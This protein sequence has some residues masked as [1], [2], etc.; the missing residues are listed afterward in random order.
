LHYLTVFFQRLRG[1]L[2][3]EH[4]LEGIEGLAIA[5]PYE[6]SVAVHARVIGCIGIGIR[7]IISVLHLTSIIINKIGCGCQIISA[8]KCGCRSRAKRDCFRTV[9]DMRSSISIVC[10]VRVIVRPSCE[11]AGICLN[12]TSTVS[13]SRK[14][15]GR[16][17]LPQS[18][19]RGKRSDF[20]FQDK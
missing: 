15:A 1:D 6:F 5:L 2:I 3:S 12:I 13:S 11:N 18:I 4:I 19:T 10:G 20:V 9:I 17:G 16:I 14:S 7:L 8:Y